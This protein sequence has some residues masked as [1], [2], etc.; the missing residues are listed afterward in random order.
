MKEA[1]NFNPQTF[2][3]SGKSKV[4]QVKGYDGYILPQ[5][6]TWLETPTFNRET[7]QCKFDKASGAWS[8][9]DK[10]QPVIA[11]SKTSRAKKEFDDVSLVTDDYTIVPPSTEFDEWCEDSCSWVTNES[12]KHISEYNEVDDTR[13]RLYSVMVTPLVDE[14]YIK[15]N[16]V[17]TEKA[18]SEADDLEKQALAARLKIQAENP[19]PPAPT[20]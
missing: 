5:F 3:F 8:I 12:N 17:K 9:Q 13:R 19:W 1:Y 14:A 7:Q 2:L 16:L 15:R 6:S 11:Y 20:D 4:Y 10:P 18:L